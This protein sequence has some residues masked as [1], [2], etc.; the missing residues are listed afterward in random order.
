LGLNGL[1]GG[2][3]NRGVVARERG[4]AQ[5]TYG[6]N[7]QVGLICFCHVLHTGVSKKTHNRFGSFRIFEPQKTPEGFGHRN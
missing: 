2:K 1:N 6:T 5:E 4:S 7:L 3:N